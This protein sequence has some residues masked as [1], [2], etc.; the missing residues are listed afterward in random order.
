MTGNTQGD[1]DDE[2]SEGPHR[3]HLAVVDSGLTEYHRYRTYMAVCGAPVSASDLPSA[4]CE[5]DCVRGLAYCTECLRVAAEAT[6]DAGVTVDLLATSQR[7]WQVAHV[8][9]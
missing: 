2:T 8:R 6:A 5:P 9:G 3:L 7:A 1:I 4:L